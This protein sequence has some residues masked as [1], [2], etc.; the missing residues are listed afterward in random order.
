MVTMKN[1]AVAVARFLVALLG[2]TIF[3]GGMVLLVVLFE[4]LRFLPCLGLLGFTL[5][6]LVLVMIGTGSWGRWAYLLMFFSMPV[7]FLVFS[8]V[9]PLTS[10]QW[11]PLVAGMTTFV[12]YYF[13][14]RYY[15]I[16]KTKN[17]QVRRG[18][19]GGREADRPA[20]AGDQTD[21]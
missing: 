7:S 3:V 15:Q 10:K 8:A 1:M 11:P 20:R 17:G 13:V 18:G 21:D 2:L 5:A 14:R 16:K 4:N 9:V 12:A 6:G 19:H